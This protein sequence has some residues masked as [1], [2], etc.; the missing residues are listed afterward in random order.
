MSSIIIKVRRSSR[1][2]S[3]AWA[4]VGADVE[5]TMDIEAS[6]DYWTIVGHLWYNKCCQGNV[7]VCV[8]VCIWVRQREC[9]R[10][11]ILMCVLFMKIHFCIHSTAT[12]NVDH[13]VF[14]ILFS[15]FFLLSVFCCCF[16]LPLYF[17]YLCPSFCSFVFGFV[18]VSPCPF[19]ARRLTHGWRLSRRA[20]TI[21]DAR[22]R[23]LEIARGATTFFLQISFYRGFI[24]VELNWVE[25]TKRTLDTLALSLTFPLYICVMLSL[26]HFPTFPSFPASACQRACVI[27]TLS[28]ALME[29][30]NEISFKL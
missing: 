26:S 5:S 9:E 6:L 15:V 16:L 8:Y 28:L 10:V 13:K 30:A 3:W 27:V 1:N 4:G 2:G 18:W 11:A 24:G 17:S 21:N 7:R 23:R 14:C 25:H 20:R 19:P 22:A 29:I 12:K